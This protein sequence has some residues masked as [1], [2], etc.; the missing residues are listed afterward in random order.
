MSD[1]KKNQVEPAQTTEKKVRKGSRLAREARVIRDVAAK[2]QAEAEEIHADAEKIEAQAHLEQAQGALNN[3]RGKKAWSRLKK[4][5][6]Y[7][8]VATITGVAA[9]VGIGVGKAVYKKP[10]AITGAAEEATTGAIKVAEA[11]GKAVDSAGDATE[12][13]AKTTKT[14]ARVVGS[15]GDFV[16]EHTKDPDFAKFLVESENQVGSSWLPGIRASNALSWSKTNPDF[17]ITKDQLEVLLE[18]NGAFK[19]ERGR[20]MNNQEALEAREK[21]VEGAKK[22]RQRLETG[23]KAGGPKTGR[24]NGGR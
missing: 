20:Y 5:G 8:L 2:K 23:S 7:V 14:V 22:C 11:A 18:Q 13:V 19:K 10:G 1:S 12:S 15:T 4:W 21:L 16:E 3:S 17:P 24:Q 6:S 9:A